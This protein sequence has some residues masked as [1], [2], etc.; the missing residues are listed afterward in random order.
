MTGKKR[1]CAGKTETVLSRNNDKVSELEKDH[2][3]YTI[4]TNT[5]MSKHYHVMFISKILSI[6]F[7]LRKM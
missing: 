4:M 7:K 2:Y 6:S 5:S 1:L 3:K